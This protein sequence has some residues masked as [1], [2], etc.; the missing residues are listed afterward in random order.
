MRLCNYSYNQEKKVVPKSSK[1]TKRIEPAGFVFFIL[2]E[3]NARIA[4]EDIFDVDLNSRKAE[5]EISEI[6]LENV[7]SFSNHC[8]KYEIA[9]FV[10]VHKLAWSRVMLSDF[11]T[12]SESETGD[13]NVSKKK[14]KKF[15]SIKTLGLVRN[16]IS[17]NTCAYELLNC[18]DS[19]ETSKIKANYR[20]LVL[21]LHPDKSNNQNVPE[22]LKEYEKKYRVSSLSRQQKSDMFLL[23]Q[24]AF[25]ILSDPDMRLEYDSNLPFDEYI[26]SNEEAKKKDFFLL[27]GPVFKMN[28]RWSR[29]KPVPLLGSNDCDDKYVE[30][31]YEFWRSFET[32]RTFSHAAPHLLEDAESRE[33][34]RWMERENLKVQ[35]KLVKKEQLR[36]Q[37]LV[38]LSQQ[39]DPRL[40]RRQDR[41]RLEKLERLK[42]VQ[43]AKQLEMKKLELER[44]KERLEL[45]Q[46]AERTKYEKQIAKKLRQQLRIVSQRDDKLTEIAKN[47]DKLT[48]FEYGEILDYSKEMYSIIKLEFNFARSANSEYLEELKSCDAQLKEFE[49]ETDISEH[50]YGLFESIS[51]KLDPPSQNKSVELTP[52]QQQTQKTELKQEIKEGEGGWTT[53]DLGRL[54]K[55]VEANPPGTP[56]RWNLISKFVRTKSAGQ[57]IEMAK[58][59]AT[60][61]DISSYMASETPATAINGAS[62]A[63]VNSTETKTNGNVTETTSEAS[64]S[65]WTNEQQTA[66]E[67]ALAKYPSHIDPLVRWRKIASEVP[68]KTPKECLSRFKEIKAAITSRKQ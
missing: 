24:D 12:L 14:E 30:E 3:W 28:S 63:T 49:M 5:F 23:L 22:D 55:A 52:A 41:L 1:K 58:L 45:Q 43:E 59:V 17:K 25:T 42:K 40:K 64:A 48:N 4:F 53:A 66:F 34:K 39:Y 38:D 50:L 57:C 13:E 36:I 47:F 54:A 11:E 16:F 26:P 29:V 7:K 20:K 10:Y 60:N 62:T 18:T 33:E 6:D 68:G 21:L 44:E 9:S 27:F 35:K 15:K 37:K 61:A 32:L 2:R 8:Q 67:Q 31:F 19:D 51:A 46:A 65:G 56:G